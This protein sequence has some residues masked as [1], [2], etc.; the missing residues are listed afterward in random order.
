MKTVEDYLDL[1]YHVE[2]VRDDDDEGNFGWVAEVEELPGC[3][4]QGKTAE[5]AASRV[6]E[7]MDAWLSVS[8][9]EGKDIPMPREEGYSGKFVVRIPSTLHAELVRAARRENVS[10]NAFTMGVLASSVGWR[11]AGKKAA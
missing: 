9:Q 6:H 10:L 1:P 7:A 2:L 5:E 11:Q 4:S 8:L 3:I